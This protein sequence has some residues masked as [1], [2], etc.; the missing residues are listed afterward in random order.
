VTE[1]TLEFIARRLDQLQADIG[2]L[3]DQN[4]VLTAMVGRVESAI[5][6]LAIELRGTNGRI[7]RLLDRIQK[8]ERTV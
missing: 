4:T 2:D 6:L 7:D 3:R 1:I 8:I 5:G